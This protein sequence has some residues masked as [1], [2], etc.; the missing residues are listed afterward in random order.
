MGLTLLT[1]MKRRPQQV[2]LWQPQKLS[3]MRLPT[4]A[5]AAHVD[6][7]QG[8]GCSWCICAGNL[9]S[10]MGWRTL[11]EAAHADASWG[12]GCSR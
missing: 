3:G 7:I 11:A 4:L 2:K 1:R 10:T 8:G 9:K 6:T 12:G 5:E